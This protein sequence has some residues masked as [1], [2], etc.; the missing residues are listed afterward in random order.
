MADQRLSKFTFM[1]K[2]L[3]TLS[4]VVKFNM[5]K[6]IEIKS[7]KQ[8]KK[9]LFKNKQTLNPD[10]N[11]KFCS[12]LTCPI[13]I[14]SF[15]ITTINL[16]T[17]LTLTVAVKTSSQGNTERCTMNLELPKGYTSQNLRACLYLMQLRI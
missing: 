6:N 3:R 16:K 8:C 10:K 14:H 15:H 2:A 17:N 9:P 7:L 1:E 13:P 11:S 12:L 4:K 5:F